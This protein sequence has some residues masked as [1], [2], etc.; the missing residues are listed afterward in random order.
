MNPLRKAI[1]WGFHGSSCPFAVPVCGIDNVGIVSVSLLSGEKANITPSQCSERH[2]AAH[3]KED[4]GS[5]SHGF[6]TYV[7]RVVLGTSCAQS[8]SSHGVAAL[9]T[10]LQQLRWAHEQYRQATNGLL[11]WATECMSCAQRLWTHQRLLTFG[12]S[13]V[14]HWLDLENISSFRYKCILVNATS[15]WFMNLAT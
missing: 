5:W 6:V 10:G 2:G 12:S 14:T 4:E 15:T 7:S 1:R 3:F 13:S 9:G 8:R 11:C